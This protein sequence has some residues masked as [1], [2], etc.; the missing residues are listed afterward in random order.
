ML[1]TLVLLYINLYTGL[2]APGLFVTLNSKNQI[3]YE[4]IFKEIKDLL[5]N[6]NKLVEFALLI[7]KLFLAKNLV[8]LYVVLKKKK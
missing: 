6:N 3:S 4:I 1:E 8:L 7:R 2:K 5:T